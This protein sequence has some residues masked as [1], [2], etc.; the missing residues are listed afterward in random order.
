MGSRQLPTLVVSLLAVVCICLGGSITEAIPATI[1]ASR[2]ERAPILWYFDANGNALTLQIEGGYCAGESR[3]IFKRIRI[4]RAAKLDLG[5]RTAFVLTALFEKAANPAP[6]QGRSSAISGG[7]PNEVCS[8]IAFS[9][10]KRVSLPGPVSDTVIYDGSQ[11]PPHRVP[12][13][14]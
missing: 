12:R 5:R 3:P 10:R 1:G 4:Q 14:H 11:T 2:L 9:V 7:E 13:L 8:G 6:R